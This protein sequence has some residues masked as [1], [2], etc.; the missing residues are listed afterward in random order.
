MSWVWSTVVWAALGFTLGA[1]ALLA[2]YWICKRRGRLWIWNLVA[3][4][5]LVAP[6]LY[7][8]LALAGVFTNE[9]LHWERVWAFPLGPLAALFTLYR[10]SRLPRATEGRNALQGLL[11][12]FI[13]CGL[14]LATAGLHVTLPV[15]N[16]MLVVAIDASRSMELVDDYDARVQKELQLVRH[17]M[18]QDD[19]VAVVA[20]ASTAHVQSGFEQPIAL[21]SPLPAPAREASNLQAAIERALAEIP[22]GSPGRIA[23]LSD[24]LANRGDVEPALARAAARSV[25]VDTVVL[26]PRTLQNVRVV[27]VSAPPLLSQGEPFELRVV[28]EASAEQTVSVHIIENDELSVQTQLALK[29]GQD[30]YRFKRIASRPGL[31]H[32]RVAVSPTDRTLDQLDTDNQLS[33][34]VQVHGASRALLL[35][36][37]RAR[38][39]PLLA[40]LRAAAFD[41]DVRTTLS[42][43]LGVTTLA[44]YD[45]VIL[46]DHPA[47][48]LTASQRDAMVSYV[49]AMGGGLLLLG[50]ARSLGPGGY[51]GTSLETVSPVAF[52]YKQGR[53]RGRL[54]QVIAIDHSGSMAA[55]VGEL[56][57]LDSASAA[58]LRSARLM[59]ADDWVGIVHV[60]V[61][62]QWT[63]PL[64]PRAEHDLEAAL[65]SLEPAGGGI[66]VPVALQTSYAAL[67]P[68]DANLKHLLLLAD[69][70]D[71]EGTQSALPLA[72]QAY[73]SGITTSVVAL[74]LGSDLPW[75]ER[76]SDLGG[77]RFHLVQ[78]A[79]RLPAV[80]AQETLAASSSALHLKRFEVHVNDQGG[81][82][83]GI[84][85]SQ[86][87]PLDGYV[88]SVAKPRARVWLQGQHGDPLLATWSIGLGRAGVFTS[89]LAEWGAPWTRWPGASQLFAQLE[90]SLVRTTT[91]SY[92]QLRAHASEGRLDI[93]ADVV[94]QFAVAQ[95]QWLARVFHPNG[96]ITEATLSPQAPGRHALSL[97]IETPGTYLVSVFDAATR[98]H[99]ATAGTELTPNDEVKPVAADRAL[100]EHVARRTN[101]TVRDTLAGVFL[102]SAAENRVLQPLSLPLLW[103]S[104]LLL[105][106]VVALR[107]LPPERRLPAAPPPR[108]SSI[109]PRAPDPTGTPPPSAVAP[110]DGSS[111]ARLLERRQRR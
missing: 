82:L 16:T 43:P 20:F 22:E 62:A 28:L 99:L 39:S 36:S 79:A 29:P 37:S 65:R 52:E 94:D 96:D 107:Q 75:L 88:I 83:R 77:G 19:R 100:L 95:Q 10:F 50:S 55:R 34:F 84:D 53:Y 64:R 48:L 69:G 3:V 71:A 13:I 8:C 104:A 108:Q 59:A 60:D 97:P 33:T 80:F 106:L 27:K 103:T 91:H 23:L 25:P 105:L 78:D 74:G 68:A 44:R 6:L 45:L 102:D 111:I 2:S 9:L 26:E 101:G 14:G 92:V 73:A 57:K 76:L 18:Q 72:E 7:T 30:V 21:A 47:Q 85:W 46:D 81:L 98:E 24:G 5:L 90:R 67:R 49:K 63:A 35:T 87:P 15:H 54:A 109:P 58:A 42:P 66:S 31:A 41:V 40:S 12:P 93:T 56:S 110:A 38:A 70:S 32:Y 11:W 4:A 86:A 89:N 1:G 61:R 17:G 51:A